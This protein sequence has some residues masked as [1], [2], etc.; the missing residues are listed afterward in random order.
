M[1]N[2][3]FFVIFLVSA[4]ILSCNKAINYSDPEGPVYQG[5][6]S[7]NIRENEKLRVVTFNTKHSENR[8]QII[9]LLGQTEELYGADVILLQEADEESTRKIAKD[10]KYNFSYIPSAIHPKTGKNFGNAIL[11]KWDIVDTEKI[12]LPETGRYNGLQRSV[13]KSLIKFNGSNLQVY[14][15]HFSTVFQLSSKNRYKQFE[16]VFD[17]AVKSQYPTIVAGDFNDKDIA[18]AAL[19]YNFDW[20]TKN[21]GGT[22]YIFS[23]DHIVTKNFQLATEISTGIVSDNLESSDHKPVW[24][25]FTLADTNNNDPA[26][27]NIDDTQDLVNT[28]LNYQK[29]VVSLG[30][31][32]RFKPYFGMSMIIDQQGDNTKAGALGYLGLYRDLTNPVMG[33]FGLSGEAYLGGTSKS[34]H[35][36]LRLLASS[37][38]LHLHAGLDYDLI[39]NEPDFIVSVTPPL[40]RG[41]L[42]GAG[43]FFRID[44]IPTRSHTFLLGFQIPLSQRGGIT[45][46][47]DKKITL[48]KSR[49]EPLNNKEFL[50]NPKVTR[51]FEIIREAAIY[52]I[53]Y[54]TFFEDPS[55]SYEESV[56]VSNKNIDEAV[57]MVTTKTPI[58]PDGKS[59]SAVETVYHDHLDNLFREFIN[60]DDESTSKL[61]TAI[62]KSLLE[63]VIIPYDRT[64]GQ[65]KRHDSILGFGQIAKSNLTEWIDNNLTIDPINKENVLSLFWKLILVIEECR[66][67]S[68]NHYKGDSRQV[69]LLYQFALLPHEHDTQEE[70]DKI[71]EQTLD[72]NFTEGNAVLVL[73]SNEFIKQLQRTILETQDYHVLWVHDDRGIDSAGKPD[74]IGLDVTLNSYLKV[75]TERVKEYDKTGKIPVFMIII[76]QFFYE[77][78]NGRRWLSLLENPLDYSVDLP[79]GYEEMETQIQDSQQK[80]REAVRNSELLTKEA[81]DYGDRY[82]KDK[83]KIHINVTQPPDFSFLSPGIVKGVP[84]LPDNI[85]IDH[86]KLAFYDLTEHYPYKGEAIFTGTGVGEHYVSPTWEDRAVLASG[87]AVFDLKRMAREVLIKNGLK[88]TDIPEVLLDSYKGSVSDNTK[89]LY[90]HKAADARALIVSNSIGYGEKN[91][92]LL[93]SVLYSLMPPDTI[94]ILPD[95]LWLSE[96]WAGLVIGAAARGCHVYII[97]PSDKNAPSPGSVQMWRTKIIIARLLSLQIR[98]AEIIK[99]NGGILRIGIFNRESDIGNVAQVLRETH[100][101][102]EKY[103][104][105]REEFPVDDIIF[106]TI[107]KIADELEAE[108]YQPIPPAEDDIPRLVNLH[109]KTRFF[110]SREVLAAFASSPAT[111]DDIKRE[112]DIFVRA[113]LEENP[114]NVF[115]NEVMEVLYPAVN[116]YNALKRS[117]SLKDDILFYSVGSMNHDPRGMMLDGEVSY[118]ISGSWALWGYLDSIFLLGQVEWVNSAEELEKYLPGKSERMR[119]IGHWMKNLL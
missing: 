70:I 65:I 73:N 34:E 84:F 47:K 9:K 117:G 108:G 83:I 12:V 69:W 105:L 99:M 103:K 50:D 45:R 17:D 110:A 79:K 37:P 98:A 2:I 86:R 67:F 116:E 62:R 97:A 11:S 112:L 113:S 74:E 60:I 96:Y 115:D 40:R 13:L 21:I 24:A 118:L 52:M 22:T 54:N 31:P 78:N 56:R 100:D 88:E 35:I 114:G 18:E 109:R 57:K 48:P 1:A 5:N 66:E 63:D 90:K 28:S 111:E 95:S 85:M 26:M 104:F 53:R 33:L 76:D 58:Y 46:P 29:P 77:I 23:W 61:F 30:Q 3:S 20:P 80:L 81:K 91:S 75:L 102:Y 41:G 19:T 25:E 89:D 101:S 8:D 72:N 27:N 49:K 64:I 119:R 87:P 15:V 6:F 38:V 7:D 59:F 14:N 82:I 4:C 93:H 32:K 44:W 36:G 92:T 51:E 43:D 10:L 42:F 106:E 71:I 68:L 16:R 39:D 107:D 94:M 55:G